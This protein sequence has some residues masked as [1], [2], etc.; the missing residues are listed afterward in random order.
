[1]PVIPQSVEQPVQIV[2]GVVQVEADAHRSG[3]ARLPA[4]FSLSVAS[5]I[6]IDKTVELRWGSMSFAQ[7][8]VGPQFWSSSVSLQLSGSPP[9]PFP[10]TAGLRPVTYAT[11][12]PVGKPAPPRPVSPD[13]SRASA[14]CH[15]TV[16]T[17]AF[18]LTPMR[19]TG[20]PQAG[21][22]ASAGDNEARVEQS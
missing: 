18:R 5:A 22:V 16:S 10:I 15:L 14:R 8:F 11:L 6:G 13:W 7:D 2:L 17:A 21:L 12:R 9:A 3:D 1:M 20:S 4:A 19:D